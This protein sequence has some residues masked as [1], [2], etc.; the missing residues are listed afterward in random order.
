MKISVTEMLQEDR[1][2]GWHSVPMKE[3]VP[4]DVKEIVYYPCLN[5][6]EDYPTAEKAFRRIRRAVDYARLKNPELGGILGVSTHRHWTPYRYETSPRGGKPKRIFNP[7]VR[8][9]TAPHIHLFLY[10][11]GSRSLIERIARKELGDNFTKSKIQTYDCFP[12]Q[13]VIQ[14]SDHFREWK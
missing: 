7:A 1:G 8:Y 10:G 2:N 12:R 3:R 6:F 4:D 9:R 13:Y 5:Q 11:R 14:Q